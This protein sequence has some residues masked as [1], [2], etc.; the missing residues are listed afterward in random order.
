MAAKFKME[1][2]QVFFLKFYFFFFYY[3]FCNQNFKMADF[4]NMSETLSFFQRAPQIQPIKLIFYFFNILKD[5]LLRE[6]TLSKDNVQND[7]HF[8]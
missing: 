3:F 5:I 2:K 1:V 8:K 7:G 6:K 4:I